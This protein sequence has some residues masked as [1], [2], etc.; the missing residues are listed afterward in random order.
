ME[1][2]P[3]ELYLQIGSYLNKTQDFANFLNIFPRE[4]S[5]KDY[6]YLF[7]LQYKTWYTPNIINYDIKELY[8]EFSGIKTIIG[9][10]FER[11]HF[12]LILENPKNYQRIIKYLVVNDLIFINLKDICI[13]D[14]IEIFEHSL[15]KLS[16]SNN[17]IVHVILKFRAFN[18]L[19]YI[20]THQKFQYY[21]IVDIIILKIGKYDITVKNLDFIR[22]ILK[23]KPNDKFIV[24]LCYD[25]YDLTFD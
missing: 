24:D 9:T 23:H 10:N 20:L 1:E 16:D 22:T 18:L 15:K 7:T 25:L 13:L 3:T 5:N 4:L 17:G 2:L 14:D 6:L 11:L 19:N 12:E 21:Q 8:V